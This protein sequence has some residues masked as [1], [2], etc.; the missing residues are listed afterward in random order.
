M[1]DIV[2]RLRGVDHESVEDCFLLSPLF[3][4]A[5]DE[6]IRLRAELADARNKALEEVNE[7]VVS[8]TFNYDKAG[9]DD[10]DQ[11]WCSGLNKASDV[12]CAMKNGRNG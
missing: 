9:S 7:K 10:Y 5:A 8:L 11:G 3:A 12:I 1:S 4:H 6:I 2:A